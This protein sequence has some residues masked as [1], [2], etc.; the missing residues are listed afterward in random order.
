MAADDGHA[1]YVWQEKDAAAS[2]DGVDPPVGR[3]GR[4]AESR[5]RWRTAAI[6]LGVL[7]VGLLAGLIAASVIAAQRAGNSC[8]VASG[9]DGLPPFNT[10]ALPPRLPTHG[11]LWPR[12]AN[13]TFGGRPPLPVA[14]NFTLRAGRNTSARLERAIVRYQARLFPLPR[15]DGDD[16]EGNSSRVLRTLTV[17]LQGGSDDA[18]P[19]HLQSESYTLRVPGDGSGATLSCASTIGCVR[20]LETFSQLIE[21]ISSAAL[22]LDAG[23]ASPQVAGYFIY[24]TPW[25]INDSPRFSHRGVMLDTSRHFFPLRDLKRIVDGMEAVKLNVFHWHITDSQSFP[26]SFAAAPELAAAGAYSPGEIYSEADVADLVTYAGDRGIRIIPEFDMPGHAASW[27]GLPNITVGPKPDASDWGAYCYVPPCGQLNVKDTS[28]AV[29]RLLDKLFATVAAL[30][31]DPLIHVGG[32]EINLNLYGTFLRGFSPN[33]LGTFVAGVHERVRAL[34]RTPVH[35]QDITDHSSVALDPKGT[36][37]QVW[38]D[39][40]LVRDFSRRGF[41][42]VASPSKWLYLDCGHGDWLSMSPKYWCDPYK[43]WRTLHLYDPSPDND[44]NV[45]GAE[46]ALWAEATDPGNLDTALWPRLAGGAERWW[47][48]KDTGV[49][50]QENWLTRRRMDAA[51]A[52]LVRRGVPAAPV[53][54]AWCYWGSGNNCE[55]SY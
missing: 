16:G 40:W 28:G 42:V 22:Y 33:D 5:R 50:P 3:E 34:N 47:S 32:D 35:W 54:P 1:A 52:R 4:T 43:T 30:F 24:D 23:R 55:T 11:F 18:V 41:R 36:V 38:G 31:P 26:F 12:P 46:A 49:L 8:I 13:W 27:S 17:N 45:L 15:A 39:D 51:R 14:R 9:G 53:W 29:G 44:P 21:P 48:P 6:A 25:L 19:I 37:I 2:A 7:S 10:S 20:G